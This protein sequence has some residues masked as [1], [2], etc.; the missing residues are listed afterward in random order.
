MMRIINMPTKNQLLKTIAELVENCK[1]LG[2]PDA[3]I[4]KILLNY[5]F[6]FSEIIEW[7]GIGVKRNTVLCPYCNG[8]SDSKDPSV[9][10]QE[11]RETFGHTFI[12]ELQEGG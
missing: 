1:E 12:D 8:E 3:A 9:L 4:A 11:C 5:G 10:C 7:Y 2:L 6:H